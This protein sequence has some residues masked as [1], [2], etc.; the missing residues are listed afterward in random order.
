MINHKVLELL[1]KYAEVEV[2]PAT[3][4]KRE[5]EN[6]AHELHLKLQAV[7]A[8]MEHDISVLK[9][10]QF[11]PDMLR[12]YTDIWQRLG[13]I[14]LNFKSYDPYQAAREIVNYVNNKHTKS[15]IDN[16]IFLTEHHVKNTNVDFTPN[17]LLKHP[18]VRGLKL[19]LQLSEFANNKLQEPT[20]AQFQETFRPPAKINMPVIQMPPLKNISPLP[21]TGK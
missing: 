14:S 20:P 12:L 18:E 19:L 16:L 6:F 4:D 11:D 21:E 9:M 15:V 2:S 8:D 13:H 7:M 5:V 17:K 1:N 3:S 10:R